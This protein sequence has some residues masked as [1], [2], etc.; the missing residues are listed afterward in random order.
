MMDVHL[1]IILK[2]FGRIDCT[3]RVFRSFVAWITHSYTPQNIEPL[4]NYSYIILF[5]IQIVTTFQWLPT[6]VAL[7]QHENRYTIRPA[8][9]TPS[10]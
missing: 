3:I 9:A 7:I 4:Y 10:L 5:K 2:I 8:G 6:E 1:L